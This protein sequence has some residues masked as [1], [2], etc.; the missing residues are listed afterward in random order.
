[1]RSLRLLLS[2]SRRRKVSLP[3]KDPGMMLIRLSSSESRK[4]FVRCTQED[5]GR[6]LTGTP[7]ATPDSGEASRAELHCLQLL[8]DGLLKRFQESGPF[9]NARVRQGKLQITLKDLSVDELEGVSG[10]ILESLKPLHEERRRRMLAHPTGLEAVPSMACV[11]EPS[12]AATALHA[13]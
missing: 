10:A 3:E 7:P 13:P 8:R 6:A 9:A 12:H 5:L 2:Y 4:P 11:G 1:M